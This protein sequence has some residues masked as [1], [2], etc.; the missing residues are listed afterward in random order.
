MLE[1]E[2]Q[3]FISIVFY[4][5]KLAKAMVFQDYIIIENMINTLQINLKK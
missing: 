1:N 5:K 2:P 3:H 4:K